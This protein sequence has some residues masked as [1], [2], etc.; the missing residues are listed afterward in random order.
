LRGH[1]QQTIE[2]DAAIRSNS[3]PN[4][5][6]L[7]HYKDTNVNIG[8]SRVVPVW[9]YDS[10][11]G[12]L[13]L[14]IKNL[15]NQGINAVSFDLDFYQRSG[16]TDVVTINRQTQGP[17]VTSI[18]SGYQ[19]FSIDRIGVDTQ[20]AAGSYAS[21]ISG[22]LTLGSLSNASPGSLQLK[23]ASSNGTNFIELKAPSNIGANVNLTLPSSTGS[24]GQTL[25]TDGSGNLSWG[26]A[27]AQPSGSNGQIQFNSNGALGAS[28][29]LS[30][31]G[32]YLKTNR[33][34]VGGTD[35]TLGT[36]GIRPVGTIT[37][38][39]AMVHDNNDQ[40]TINYDGDFEGGTAIQSNLSV[41]GATSLNDSLTM[42]LGKNII[43]RDLSETRHGRLMHSNNGNFHIDSFGGGKTY[44]NYYGGGQVVIGNKLTVNN[45]ID[46]VAFNAT[47]DYRLKEQIKDIT[48]EKALLFI[49]NARPV[50]YK[51]KNN[52]SEAFGFISQEVDKLGFSEMVSKS[53]EEGLAESVDSDGYVSP[54]D[55]K[56]LLNYNQI[57][58][59]LTK[60]LQI[61]RTQIKDLIARIVSFEDDVK[62]LKDEFKAQEKAIA[63]LKEETI[64]LSAKKAHRSAGAFIEN[65][66]IGNKEKYIAFGYKGFNPELG[67]MSQSFGP[68]KGIAGLEI[69]VKGSKDQG[70]YIKG[71][72]GTTVGTGDLAELYYSSQKLELGDLV[73]IDPERPGAVIRSDLAYENSLIGVVSAKPFAL[74]MALSQEKLDNPNY[75][76]VSLAGKMLVKISLENGPIKAGDPLTSSSAPGYAMKATKSS[77]IIGHAFESYDGSINVTSGVEEMF[78]D[79]SA[80]CESCFDQM[81][82]YEKQSLSEAGTYKKGYV[83]ALV[84]P[85]YYSP[86][87]MTAKLS[88]LQADNQ[89]GFEGWFDM[90]NYKDIL[91]N[92]NQTIKG[93]RSSMKDTISRLTGVESEV[94]ELKADLDKKDEAIKELKE[95]NKMMKDFLCGKY[96]D[97][98]MCAKN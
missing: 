97:A 33:L 37:S 21:E 13:K 84:Q 98:P 80:D 8:F 85:S 89:N 39:R 63:E 46:A 47:S 10:A 17:E 20:L 83:L 88:P 66:T 64:K 16:L 62:E 71:S 51:W 12:K 55:T 82:P 61:V 50:H 95:E 18:P 41:S 53:E 49:D 91:D 69:R 73:G 24:A 7:S 4:V 45:E 54:K 75:H 87:E 52:D 68:V 42:R 22:T 32:T 26:V 28:S 59:I 5:I 34:A 90:D 6:W 74:L 76:P 78:E 92:V 29:D 72:G 15:H 65:G 43:I 1:E 40:L 94:E 23:E 96:Q 31:D 86:V 9:W 2:L 57:I 93:I 79:I 44:I 30:W 60:A 58:P 3:L 36:S 38:Q 70:I 56:I 25:I 67:V 77:R 14:A 19:E 11:S 35:F 27:G 81:K 48:D